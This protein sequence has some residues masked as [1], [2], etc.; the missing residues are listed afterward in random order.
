MSLKVRKSKKGVGKPKI[1]LGGTVDYLDEHW[2][3]EGITIAFSA[4][5]YIKNLIPKFEKL[6]NKELKTYNTPME[7][8]AHPELDDSP[9]LSLEQISVFRGGTGSLN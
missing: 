7:N 2:N 1:F 6:F 3:K 5:T 4:Q 8:D 9:F